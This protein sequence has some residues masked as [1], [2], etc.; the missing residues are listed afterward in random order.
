M[1]GVQTCALPISDV[2]LVIDSPTP[3]IQ[4]H[5][6]P[7]AGAKV[8]H[9]ATDPLFAR[10]PVRSFPIDLAI[11]ANASLGVVAL[12]EE[13]AKLNPNVAERY[14]AVEA[15]NK[16]RREASRKRAM[17]GNGSPMTPGYVGHCLSEAM[18]DKALFFSELGAPIESMNMK[19]ANRYLNNP[20]SGGDR[21]ST[22]LNSSHIPLSRMPSSA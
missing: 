15:K 10:W 16:A 21:K 12:Q 18:D 8:I 2:I 13:M 19:G 6:K 14:K 4:R 17:G 3:W 7:M 22:R 5:H 11:T 20:F 1:T 9:L